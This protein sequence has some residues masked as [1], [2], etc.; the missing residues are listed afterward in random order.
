[1]SLRASFIAMILSLIP[2]FAYGYDEAD[3]RTYLAG[4]KVSALTKGLSETAID[5]TLATVKYV[6]KAVKLDRKQNEFTISFEKYQNNQ[7]PASRVKKAVS[8]LQ[9]YKST[10]DR[11]EQI[12][13]VP[14]EMIVALW[15]IESNF[16]QNTGGFHV[17]SVLATL[18]Y[19]G[20]R[21]VLF[22]NQLIHSMQIIQEG[23]VRPT[24]MKGSWAGAMGQSQF[25]PSSF[26]NYAV[27]FSKDGTKDIW[28]AK[29]DVWASIA[30]Y[31]QTEGWQFGKPKAVAVQL[32]IDFTYDEEIYAK[33]YR[34]LSE[35]KNMGVRLFENVSGNP[36]VKL[37]KPDRSTENQ[38]FIAFENFDVIMHWNRSH[39]FALTVAKLA[40]KI[41]A[42]L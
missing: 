5:Q 12:Y 15:A 34:P 29:S 31:L 41:K 6:P 2:A 40:D 27:D 17:P 37:I 7:L 26:L 3:F 35:F 33:H 42:R 20:R 13:K 11:I 1:M 9:T 36:N 4:V 25:M 10:F 24:Q 28:R 30:N 23:H 22:E 39:F 38:A 8:F 18:A 21:R 32:P 14:R 16:G 19:D